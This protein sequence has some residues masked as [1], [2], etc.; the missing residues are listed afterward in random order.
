MC[1]HGPIIDEPRSGVKPRLARAGAA[2]LCYV[3][4]KEHLGLPEK[5]DV[6]VGIVSFVMFEIQ[7]AA[8]AYYFKYYIG[9]EESVQLFNVP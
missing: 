4:P 6:R 2:M 9:Q 7:N 5:E 3:T 1:L 8:I